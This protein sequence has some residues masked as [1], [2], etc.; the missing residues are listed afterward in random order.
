MSNA[1]EYARSAY[2]DL[3]IDTE[4]VME[5]LAHKAISINCWQGDDVQGFDQKDNA[6]SGGIQTTGNY[7]GKARTF[8]ELTAD[9][10]EAA[11]MIPGSKRINLHSSYAVFT[12]ENPWVDRDKLEY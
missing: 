12:E 8:E 6:A 4:A 2:A 10:E 5:T 7:P 9:F 1:Y 11:R 3:G